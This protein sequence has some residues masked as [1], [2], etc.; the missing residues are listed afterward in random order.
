M[1]YEPTAYYIPSRSNPQ[2]P[3]FTQIL[4]SSRSL[5]RWPGFVVEEMQDR[6]GSARDVTARGFRVAMLLNGGV[7][8]WW[9]DQGFGRWRRGSPGVISFAPPGPSAPSS[10]KGLRHFALVSMDRDFVA[11]VVDAGTFRRMNA[12]T[13]H[14]CLDEYYAD[15]ST[16][17]QLLTSLVWMIRNPGSFDPLAAEEAGLAL[18]EWMTRLAGSRVTL[19]PC[20]GLSRPQVRLVSDYIDANIGSALS[21]TSLAQLVNVSPF[22]F[23]RLF[24]KSTGLSP[25]RYVLRWRVDRAIEMLFTHSKVSLSAIAIACGFADQS[26]LTRVFKRFSGRTPREYARSYVA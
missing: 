14:Y 23:S 2:S 5:I 15:A 7:E 6:G 21:I 26:H 11:S 18:V 24:K 9:R 19:D 3:A 13:M 25:W 16:C 12:M 17:Q 1:R 20:D 22:H 10:W 4:S 8:T